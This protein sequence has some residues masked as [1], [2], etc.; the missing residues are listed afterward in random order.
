MG[1]REY[2]EITCPPVSVSGF[3]P[4]GIFWTDQPF[5]TQLGMMLRNHKPECLS[6]EKQINLLIF[7]ITV[8]VKA[9]II[10]WTAD[11]FWKQT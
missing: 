2:I 10:L 1:G 4:N 5:V 7:K 6:Y 3:C 9:H 8:I 11:P